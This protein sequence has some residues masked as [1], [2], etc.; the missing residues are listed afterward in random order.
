[1]V[2]MV[3]CSVC[4]GVGLVFSG[5]GALHVF[6]RGFPLVSFKGVSAL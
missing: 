2:L 4:N 6:A 5:R 3:W 1:M